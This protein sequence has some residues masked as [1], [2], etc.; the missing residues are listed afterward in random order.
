MVVSRLNQVLSKPLDELSVAI[1]KISEGNLKLDVDYKSDD[2]IGV[3]CDNI[4]DMGQKISDIVGV[5][6]AG[7]ETLA[8]NSSQVNSTSQQVMEGSM[9]QSNN[10][11]DLSA[12]MQEMTS[13]IEQNTY[14]A[15]KTN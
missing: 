9:S 8:A 3:M 1:K 13:N 4:R 7:A 15:K 2:E 11:E 5:I 14:N 10:I 12:T 6:K